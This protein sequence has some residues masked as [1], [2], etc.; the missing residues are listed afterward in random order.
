MVLCSVAVG[1]FYVAPVWKYVACVWRLERHWYRVFFCECRF[2][3]GQTPADA[4]LGLLD[5]A[6]KMEHYGLRLYPAKVG[7]L[8]V[9]ND[10]LLVSYCQLE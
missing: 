7:R 6:R 9:E 4:D 10:V 3:S 1:A 5:I 8:V 2:C